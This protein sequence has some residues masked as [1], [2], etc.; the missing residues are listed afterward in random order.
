MRIMLLITCMFVGCGGGGGHDPPAAAEPSA[1]MGVYAGT[2]EQSPSPGEMQHGRMDGTIDSG[3]T[4]AGLVQNDSRHIWNGVLAGQI[5]EDG[6]FTAL[7]TYPDY[8]PIP[9][10]GML[11]FTDAGLT[12]W[13]IQGLPPDELSFFLTLARKP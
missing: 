6:Q 2:W 13:Y 5:A 12:G 1:Y 10:R 3:G 11:A 7:V 8:A 4:M 9:I